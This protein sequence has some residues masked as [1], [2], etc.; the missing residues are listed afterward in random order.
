M[1]SF[2]CLLVGFTALLSTVG[3]TGIRVV[4]NGGY[5]PYDS[6]MPGCDT[7]GC[8][9]VA[10]VG[11]DEGHCGP[12]IL[13]RVGSRLRS[14]NC[15]SGC[16]E[17]YW[18]EQINEPRVCDPCCY[19]GDFIGGENCGRC[20]GG[21]A[22]LRELWGFRYTPSDCVTCASTQSDHCQTCSSSGVIHE[23]SS[24]LNHH[25]QTP[26]AKPQPTPAAPPSAPKADSDSSEEIRSAVEAVPGSSAKVRG[27][28][29][30]TRVVS[31]PRL[32]TKQAVPRLATR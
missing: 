3:C 17:V 4:H 1:K 2:V 10:P 29:P 7:C 19:N 8:E 31:Q 13:H 27:T 14:V 20:P 28:G 12:G 6:A 15:S 21:L 23:Q 25:T 22:R 32:T 30:A 5:G 16:G 11:C 24:T 9:V 18:D 26:S